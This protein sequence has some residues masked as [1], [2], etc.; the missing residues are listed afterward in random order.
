MGSLH[1][2]AHRLPLLRHPGL[3]L[4]AACLLFTGCTLPPSYRQQY[5]QAMHNA[6]PKARQVA[7]AQSALS[8]PDRQIVSN[9]PPRI[10]SFIDLGVLIECR[11]IWE[12]PDNRE[13]SINCHG[14]PDDNPTM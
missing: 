8:E 3:S 7:L 10:A 1:M 12:L 13:I 5:F 2:T 4:I 6:T 11:Y 9:T 14:I